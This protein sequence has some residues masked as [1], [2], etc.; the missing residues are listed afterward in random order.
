MGQSLTHFYSTASRQ[1]RKIILAMDKLKWESMGMST[2]A[3]EWH[4][5]ADGNISYSM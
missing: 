1:G 4:R 2:F 5:K 3:C